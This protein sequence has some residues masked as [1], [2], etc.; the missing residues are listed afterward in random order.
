MARLLHAPLQ[1]GRPPVAGP[2]TR[3]P[4]AVQP[5]PNAHAPARPRATPGIV[6]SPGERSATALVMKGTRP[7]RRRRVVAIRVS[8]TDARWWFG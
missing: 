8:E 7:G 4:A 1:P 3:G 2:T 5:D 6:A